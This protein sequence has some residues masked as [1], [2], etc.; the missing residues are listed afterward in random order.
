MKRRVRVNRTDFEK[1]EVQIFLRKLNFDFFESNDGQ[2]HHLS[3]PSDGITRSKACIFWTTRDLCLSEIHTPHLSLVDVFTTS[4]C[5]T[6]SSLL[7]ASDNFV[8][9]YF[10]TALHSYLIFKKHLSFLLCSP[11]LHT[12]LYRKHDSFSLFGCSQ[13]RQSQSTHKIGRHL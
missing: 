3:S 8:P 9:N 13:K 7:R 12:A 4:L 10:R 11:I 2:L 5:F 1:I 6:Q